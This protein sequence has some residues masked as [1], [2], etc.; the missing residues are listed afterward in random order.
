VH[1]VE[2]V[3]MTRGVRWKALRADKGRDDW[4]GAHIREGVVS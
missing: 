4:Q 1:Y 3:G 2:P